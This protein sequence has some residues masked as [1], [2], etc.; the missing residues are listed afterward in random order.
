[1]PRVAAPGGLRGSGSRGRE[2]YVR[3]RSLSAR[4]PQAEGM[5]KKEV[6]MGKQEERGKKEG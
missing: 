6:K 1:L 2:E 4:R 3:S 5:G